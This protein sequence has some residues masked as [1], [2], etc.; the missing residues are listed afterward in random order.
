[1]SLCHFTIVPCLCDGGGVA[2]VP[3]DEPGDHLLEG[4]ELDAELVLV[5]GHLGQ[6]LLL[7]L[8]PE[9]LLLPLVLVH[10]HVVTHCLCN[11]QL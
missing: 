9:L 7:L 3:A 5:P 10:H 1:M 4:G 11:D 8:Q 2:L 6:L